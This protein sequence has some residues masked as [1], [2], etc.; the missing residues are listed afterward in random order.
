VI[1]P[2]GFD[3]TKKHPKMMYTSSPDW[4]SDPVVGNDDTTVDD[5]ETNDPY[6]N[7]GKLTGT[8]DPLYAPLHEEGANGDTLEIRFHC[9]EFTR[10]EINGKWYRISDDF[11]WR[12]HFKF[13]K[14]MGKWGDNGSDSA[15]D[16]AGW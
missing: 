1:N 4:P 12:A 6:A 15:L 16:N 2:S 13:I 11:L 10:L 3:F 7:M 14:A 5:P 8:D 9:R